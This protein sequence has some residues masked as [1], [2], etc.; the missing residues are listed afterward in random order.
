[1]WGPPPP[2][3]RTLRSRILFFLDFYQQDCL[4]LNPPP[5]SSKFTEDTRQERRG[6]AR[7]RG[8]CDEDSSEDQTT[9][10]GSVGRRGKEGRSVTPSVS[11]DKD[12]PFV[13][14]LMHVCARVCV[15]SVSPVSRGSRVKW[16]SV[17]C[18]NPRVMWA[19]SRVSGAE[20]SVC[21][22]LEVSVWVRRRAS[23]TVSLGW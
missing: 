11:L 12:Y 13:S 17:S 19:V 7:I 14:A 3:S 16:G 10:S 6:I 1:M 8:T 9:R 2:S 18:V 21:P 5:F 15:W 22:G 23:V 4:G 20:E